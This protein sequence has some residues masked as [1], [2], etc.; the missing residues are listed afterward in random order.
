MDARFSLWVLPIGKFNFCFILL[1]KKD[2]CTWFCAKSVSLITFDSAIGLLEC[3]LWNLLIFSLAFSKLIY[4]YH[5]SNLFHFF[6]FSIYIILY[7]ILYLFVFWQSTIFSIFYF[8]Y[9]LLLL[10]EIIISGSGSKTWPE[11]ALSSAKYSFYR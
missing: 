4:S 8:L 7:C 1:L 2:Q 3:C 5:I 11:N 10:F 9:V 6:Q